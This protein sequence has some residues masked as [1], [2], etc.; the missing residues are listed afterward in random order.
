[1]TKEQHA[2]LAELTS[3]LMDRCISETEYK[4]YQSLS[5]LLLLEMNHVSVQQNNKTQY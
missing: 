1:M 5:E 4:E 3:F 2:R